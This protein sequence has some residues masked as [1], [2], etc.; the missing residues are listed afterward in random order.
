MLSG[1]VVLLIIILLCTTSTV[2]YCNTAVILLQTDTS[3]QSETRTTKTSKESITWHP[4]WLS[5]PSLIDQWIALHITAETLCTV[6]R[7]QGR[8]YGRTGRAG[9]WKCF[10]NPGERLTT[11]DREA[12]SLVSIVELLWLSISSIYQLVEPITS[13]SSYPTSRG[14]VHR[15]GEEHTKRAG[16]N[17]LQYAN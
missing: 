12:G 10:N 16:S 2:S 14:W 8:G 4:D 5:Y 13:K 15:H 11:R 3:T 9:Q 17:Q 7:G 6:R 1:E